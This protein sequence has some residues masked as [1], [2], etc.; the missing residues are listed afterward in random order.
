MRNRET[1]VETVRASAKF[2]RLDRVVQSMR[3]KSM[4]SRFASWITVLVFAAIFLDLDGFKM[5][6]DRYGHTFG[7][8]VLRTVAAR[9]R[10]EVRLGDTVARWAGDEFA[11][12]IEDASEFARPSAST[13]LRLRSE[14][15]SAPPFTRAKRRRPGRCWSWPI[16]ACSGTRRGAGPGKLPLFRAPVL[17]RERYRASS[18]TIAPFSNQRLPRFP[19]ARRRQCHHAVRGQAPV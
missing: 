13:G 4:G 11:I 7:D 16:S 3:E 9:I 17:S 5:I 15:R 19:S 1:G 10:D 18:G 12:V 2:L 14:H 6:N 8:A